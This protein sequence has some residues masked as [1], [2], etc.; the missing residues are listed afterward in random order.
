MTL[1]Y[2]V[3]MLATGFL[4][5]ETSAQYAWWWPQ[6]RMDARG[7]L[8]LS[9]LV[10]G[11]AIAQAGF[12]CHALFV[13]HLFLQQHLPL[14]RELGTDEITSG[15]IASMSFIANGTALHLLPVWRINCPEWSV[16]TQIAGRAVVIGTL[17]A[18][19]LWWRL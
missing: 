1:F 8:L 4:C 16:R 19:V 7:N 17:I 13:A 18:L 6:V 10:L 11:I 15:L 3:L 9:K 2:I 14:Q 5:A 12:A